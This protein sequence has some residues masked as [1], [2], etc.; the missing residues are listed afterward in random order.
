MVNRQ[1]PEFVGRKQELALLTAALEAALSQQ[2]QMVMLAG[3]PGIG[4][5]CT[6]QELARLAEEAGAHVVWGWCYEGEGA[7]PHWPWVDS[8]RTYIQRTEQALLR[9][10]L[11]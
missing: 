4:K 3:E 7:P 2:G 9:K 6:A 11:G 10:Q 8:L 5:T 1:G